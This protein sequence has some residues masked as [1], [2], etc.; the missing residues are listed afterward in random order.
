MARALVILLF[1]AAA[2]R[3]G[4]VAAT[5]RALRADDR[6]RR[7]E[8]L[9][10]LA[11]GDVVPDGA[12]Q[13]SR[14]ERELRRFLSDRSAGAERALAVRALGR[15]ARPALWDK[16]I[17]WLAQERDD[18]VLA[19]GADV[20]LRAPATL[21][22]EL[23]VRAGRAEDPLDRAVLVRLL[24]AL[25]G[26]EARQRIRGRAGLADHWTVRATALHAL[27]ADKD[28][29]AL[30]ILVQALDDDDPAVLAAAVESLT[31]LTG[32]DHGNDVSAWKAWWAT[33]SE[34]AKIEEALEKADPDGP[35][36]Y[37]HEVTRR[38]F[39]RKLFG[40]PVTG[41]KLAVVF[42]VSASMRYKLPLAF[43]QIAGV[44]KS[45]PSTT[46]FEI[47]FFNE[48]VWPWK[49][50]LVA[51]DP[52]TKALLIEHLDSLEIRSYTNLF[53]ALESALS[54]DPEEIFVISDGEPNRGRRQLARDILRELE[55]INR[56]PA[57]IHTI[58]VVRVVDGDEHVALLADI[59][60]ANGGQ[61]VQRTLK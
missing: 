57:R 29:A 30:T 18:R 34:T 3:A 59:A 37:A 19:A 13:L 44:V 41:R 10:A 21:A 33:R 6:D 17:D 16:L 22:L 12:A 8:A 42:D 52:V 31:E 20:F 9:E 32:L 15:I 14:A 4:D 43:D 25:P 49:G 50:R 51:A 55:R 27:A 26:P 58:S 45:L 38:T 54:L 5:M 28:P 23:S 47:V 1:L 61:H 24:G 11:S 48:H 60:A 46:T 2:A 36:R 7:R 35:R 39:A 56:R 53:D 40:I